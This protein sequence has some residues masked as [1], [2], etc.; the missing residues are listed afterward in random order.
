[1]IAQAPIYWFEEIDSTSEEAKRRAKRGEL[2]PIWIAARQQASGKGRLGRNWLS[3]VG[4]L[5]TTVLFP[6][7][8]G[9][10]VAA[11]VPF[12]AA[13]AV[14]DSCLSAVPDLDAKLKWPNDVRVQGHKL[15][16]I[17]TESG[18]TQGTTWVALGIG[19]N[20]QKVPETVGQAATCLAYEGGSPA[21]TP[22]IVLEALRPA[23]G[24]RLSQA[25]SDFPGLL[26]DWEQAAEGLGQLVQ[27]GPTDNRIEGVFERLAE[28]GG[29]I[30]RLPDGAR[31]TIR[32]GDVELVKR[33]G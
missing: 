32:A 21:L 30:L 18:E 1:M 33:V 28:D 9:L 14:R 3:P 6:E 8:G 29:L 4:N 27:A 11:R 7:P 12:A 31:R 26:S 10:T 19:M 20:I 13:L 17:L 22:D 15:S 23:M 2:S 5:Y 16:G 25:R 24:R